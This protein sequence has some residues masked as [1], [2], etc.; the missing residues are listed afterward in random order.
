[1][2][3]IEKQSIR[4]TDDFGY[5]H[6]IFHIFTRARTHTH[7]HMHGSRLILQNIPTEANRSPWGTHVTNLLFYQWQMT[8]VIA[9]IAT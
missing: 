3:L 1:M 8:Q 9:D 6:G 5:V 7:T 2:A 4:V